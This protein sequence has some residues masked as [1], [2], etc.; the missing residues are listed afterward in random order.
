MESSEKKILEN[1][2]N[3]ND[4]Y[5]T[6]IINKSYLKLLFIYPIFIIILIIILLYCIIFSIVIYNKIFEIIRIL[7]ANTKKQNSFNEIILENNREIFDEA[8]KE[9]YLNKQNYFCQNLSLFNNILVEKKIEIVKAKFR[10]LTFDMYV[11]KNGDAVSKYISQ[12]GNWEIRETKL[13]SLSLDYYSKKTNIAKKDIYMIDIG[14]N[15][16]W[17]SLVFGKKGYNILSFEPS[18][19][20]YYILLKNYCLNKNINVIIINKGL[21]TESK[22]HTLYHP[23]GNIGNAI[24]YYNINDS[25][26][27]N[28]VEEK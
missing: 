24:V 28:Y 18:K 11:Y 23:F 19:T 10:N 20:N 12:Y 3:T 13:L 2:S 22:N 25:K 15:I 4:E 17:F 8:E 16:G 21:D 14:A 5:N 9:K 1:N 7:K 6:N 26:K 27:V